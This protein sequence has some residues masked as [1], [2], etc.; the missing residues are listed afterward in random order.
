MQSAVPAAA[1]AAAVI[2]RDLLDVQLKKTLV[3]MET[4]LFKLHHLTNNRPSKNLAS[5][6][7]RNVLDGEIMVLP[8][9]KDG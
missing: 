4:K 7:T 3:I 8:S 5:I 9:G 6:A 2:T 1:A